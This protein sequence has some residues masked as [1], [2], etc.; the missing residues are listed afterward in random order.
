[1]SETC[2]VCKTECSD[3][4]TV[5]SVCRFTD[6][7]G[8][9]RTW[10][11][12]ED[13]TN[14]LEMVVKPYR[15]V[16]EKADLLA[17]LEYAKK[18][19][20]ELLAQLDTAKSNAIIQSSSASTTTVMPS[21]KKKHTVLR[22]TL[23]AVTVFVIF[24]TLMVVLAIIFQNDIG[25]FFST[26]VIMAD[27]IIIVGTIAG[28]IKKN[29]VE[30]FF[31]VSLKWFL[32]GFEVLVAGFFG[33][34]SGFII[35][36]IGAKFIVGVNIL[37]AIGGIIAMGICFV[38]IGVIIYLIYRKEAISGI[39]P[40]FVWIVAGVISGV[41][42]LFFNVVGIADGRL[43]RGIGL[44]NVIGILGFIGWLIG[45]VI[46]GI[47]GWIIIRKYRTY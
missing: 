23:I 21:T 42:N 40:F 13:A 9:N 3:E 22:N 44:F 17:Q 18:Q 37:L 19:N 43:T 45:I 26:V 16:W 38:S 5:C 11:I 34:F 20:T 27:L 28:I 39:V 6:E 33:T 10:T 14:W 4:A 29:F 31:E 24:N 30:G 46:G 15:A 7:L 12:K 47:I 2:P 25:V 35:Q 8:I 32:I 1:M 41:M 36:A